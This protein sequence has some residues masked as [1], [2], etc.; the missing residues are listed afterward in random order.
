MNA[1]PLSPQSFVLAL[2]AVETAIG[3]EM[4]GPER[5]AIYVLTVRYI[6]TK[7]GC[8]AS[9]GPETSALASLLRSHVAESGRDPTAG[10]IQALESLAKTIGSSF[11][12][13]PSR[14][15]DR[16]NPRLGARS[17][18]GGQKSSKSQIK[19]SRKPI[20]Q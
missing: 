6:A 3:R 17:A 4:Q 12:A 7:T 8:N 14:G 5:D 10:D 19:I 1:H 9:V 13:H 20:S 2:A 18:G 15:G 16:R 11:R